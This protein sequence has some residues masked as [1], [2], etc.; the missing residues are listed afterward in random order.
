MRDTI[1]SLN[2]DWNAML[3]WAPEVFISMVMALA[4]GGITLWIREMPM[5]PNWIAPVF[6][7]PLIA[8]GAGLGWFLFTDGSRIPQSL[9]NPALVRPFIAAGVGGLEM[10]FTVIL[11][12]FGK[13][14]T[15]RRED[16]ATMF[17]HK[18][19]SKIKQVATK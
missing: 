2:V 11:V 14:F 3:H 10:F 4:A 5:V 12:F 7:W 6:A 17:F 8:I 16:D 19:A 13:K 1:N 18:G 9:S 15:R